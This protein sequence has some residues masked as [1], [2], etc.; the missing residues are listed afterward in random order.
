EDVNIQL[1]KVI[2]NNDGAQN[3]FENGESFEF[4]NNFVDRLVS[5]RPKMGISV[6][7]LEEGSGVKITEVE[8]NSDAAK[9]GLL[10]GDIITNFNQVAINNV[11]EMIKQ[12]R[13]IKPDMKI[14]VSYKRNGKDFT[15]TI[16]IKKKIE[17]ANL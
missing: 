11:S 5:D 17:E 3:N 4:L 9:A 6:E 8:Q 7:D 16:K 10:K 12:A 15:T 2:R 14:A 1:K 13:T